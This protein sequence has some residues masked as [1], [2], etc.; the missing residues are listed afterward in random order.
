MLLK[1]KNTLVGFIN[2]ILGIFGCLCWFICESSMNKKN[3][4]YIYASDMQET[5]A[6]IFTAIL[7]IPLT[8]TLIINIIYTFKNWHNKKICL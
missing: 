2:I 8:L 6:I 3:S 7:L 1:K 4:S 5:L